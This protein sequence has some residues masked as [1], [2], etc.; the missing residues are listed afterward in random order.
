MA[1]P[2]ARLLPGT[3][4]LPSPAWLAAIP[5]AL[6]ATL[7]PGP[8]TLAALAAVVVLGVPHGALDGELA[9]TVL[10]PR[11]GRFWFPVFA[12]PYLLLSAGV[13]LAWRALPLVTLAGFLLLSVLH[14]G[15][16]DA[17]EGDIPER[18]ARGGLPVAL[19]VLLWP[20]A[21]AR[22][23][24]T[25]AGVPLEAPPPWLLAA[26]LAWLLPAALVLLRASARPAASP[27]NLV[28]P[29][30]LLLAFVALPPVTAFATYFVCAHAPRHVAALIADPVRAP[31]LRHRADAVRH[32]LPVFAL[33]LLLGAL[34]W[35]LYAGPAPDRLLALTLQGLAALT[36]PHLLLEA[37]TEREARKRV[38]F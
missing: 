35:P 12:L 37:W 27:G 3:A 36:V 30:V 10:R 4:S 26:A 28:E 7:P 18:L 11:L 31:R 24:G 9:R 34:L 13:L 20:A 14:F 8:R 2:T 21:T 6:S 5:L 38:L 15:A 32:A 25:V 19:P 33:T 22:L 17:P 29:A 16:E 23:L 1:S